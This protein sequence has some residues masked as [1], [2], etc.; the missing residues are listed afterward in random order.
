MHDFH[1]VDDAVFDRSKYSLRAASKRIRPSLIRYRM[2][3]ANK[4][5]C[6]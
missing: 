6:A 4:N 5:D 2:M 3:I 1:W